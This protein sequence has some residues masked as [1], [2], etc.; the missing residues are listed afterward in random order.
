LPAFFACPDERSGTRGFLFGQAKR[1]S[2]KAP[3][4]IN[5]TIYYLKQSNPFTKEQHLYSKQD[6]NLPNDTTAAQT[7]IQRSFVP[8]EDPAIR[9][10]MQGQKP[11]LYLAIRP[12]TMQGKTV[13][14]MPQ[15]L[16]SKDCLRWLPCPAM[17]GARCPFASP[18]ERIGIRGLLFFINCAATQRGK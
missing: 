4:A 12:K 3:T 11:G 16:S 8:Q 10:D 1:D 17:V 2:P 5:K 9:Q 18:D 13:F 7:T 15:A 14:I 6:R